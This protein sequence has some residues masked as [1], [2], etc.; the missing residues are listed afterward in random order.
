MKSSP[1]F[2]GMI[3]TLVDGVIMMDK[4]FIKITVFH[5]YVRE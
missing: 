2:K 3:T 4:K 1:K 5:G